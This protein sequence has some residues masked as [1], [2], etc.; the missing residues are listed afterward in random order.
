MSKEPIF[1]GSELAGFLESRPNGRTKVHYTN[2]RP[3]REYGSRAVAL[4][5]LHMHY[6]ESQGRRF[7]QL[8]HG[9]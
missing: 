5:V 4:R 2:N 6:Q 3:G 9:V 8:N 1:S 7:M